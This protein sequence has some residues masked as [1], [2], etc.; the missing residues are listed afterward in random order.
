M[1]TGTVNC[2]YFIFSTPVNALHLYSF[3]ISSMSSHLTFTKWWVLCQSYFKMY[4]G[5]SIFSLKKNRM[6]L[7]WNKDDWN[8]T[9]QSVLSTNIFTFFESL[10]R[11]FTQLAQ[12]LFLI[13]K[14][15]PWIHIV[16]DSMGKTNW[17]KNKTNAN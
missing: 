11:I 5:I 2:H 10:F 17:T 7:T 12:Q 13:P 4:L 16:Y 15:T 8:L 6:V 9:K 14:L 3:L 1:L